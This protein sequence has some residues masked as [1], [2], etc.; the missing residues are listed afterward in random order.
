MP[1]L[2]LCVAVAMLLAASGA[3]PATTDA[4][5]ADPGSASATCS[6]ETEASNAFKRGMTGAKK[7]FF[8]T[9]RSARARRR[10]V[11]QQ[12][13][14]LAKLRKARQRCLAGPPGGGEPSPEPA[15]DRV[16]P[17]ARTGSVPAQPTVGS[18]LHRGRLERCGGGPARRGR[19]ENGVEYV[20]TQLELELEDDA[21][22]AEMAALLTRLNA[23]VVSSLD[24]VGLLTVRIPDPGDLDA[25]RTLV[26]GLAGAP[27]LAHADLLTLPVITELPDNV[28]ASDVSPV[29]PQLAS[30]ASGAWNARG[31][32][33][34][35]TAPGLLVADFF[36][37][38]PPGGEVAATVTAS[39]FVTG[40]PH[41]HG[42]TVLGM[43]AAAFEPGATASLQADQATGMWPGP[44]LPLR[45]IDL[46]NS[47][48]G[49]ALQDRVLQVAAWVPQP[50]HDLAPQD[51]AHRVGR[52]LLDED[53]PARHLVGRQAL[54]RVRAARPAAPVR[55]PRARRQRRPPRRRPRPAGRRPPRPRHRRACGARPP[56]R[57]GRR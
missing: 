24:G 27:G 45:V 33:S 21:T 57:R 32:L 29:R 36:G 40:N 20:R 47:L 44:A 28:P 52:Q 43:A 11:K 16:R 10:F 34:G 2:A 4:R 41:T 14:R 3:L 25:L 23:Q 19:T 51:L 38:G 39:D 18:R 22:A 30:F 48:A 7:R 1:R 46:R 54:P 5:L 56:P 15:P 9:H 6:V 55:R 35:A 53:H 26:S 49:S 12:K 42:Y 50:G 17:C 31:A 37:A 8:K 13:R